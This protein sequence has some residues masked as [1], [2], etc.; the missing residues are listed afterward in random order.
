MTWVRISV[1]V[2]FTAAATAVLVV[3]GVDRSPGK[4]VATKYGATSQGREFALKLDRDHTPVAFDTEL[5][6][7]CPSGRTVSMP[8]SSVDGDG[9]AFRHAGDKL[10]VAERS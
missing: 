9:V 10:H 4:A 8:W 2:L 3:A 7:L 6:A 1:L 5:V